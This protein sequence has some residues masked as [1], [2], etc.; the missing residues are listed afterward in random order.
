MKRSFSRVLSGSSLIAGTMIGAGML[1]I[2]LLTANCGFFPAFLITTLVWLFMAC[3]GLLFLEA[4]LWAPEG[5]H[6]LTISEI[7]LGKKGK[8]LTGVMFIFLYYCL[9]VA[10]LAAGGPLLSFGLSDM[11][12]ELSRS[13]GLLLFTL[14]FGGIVAIGSRSIDR[15]NL[16][17]SVLMMGAW[18]CLM[19]SGMDDVKLDYL[20]YTNWSSIALPMPILFSAF[21][22]HNLIPSLSTYL[23][24]DRRSLRTAIWLG[25][26][27]AFFVYVCW[28][29]LILGSMSQG[30]MIEALKEGQPITAVFQSVTR[31]KWFVK[32]AQ[33][34]SFFAIATSTLGVSFSLVDFLADGCGIEKRK[35]IRRVALA[36][37]VF[38]P[39]FLLAS[40]YPHV[41]TLSLEVAG[42]FGEA[43][44]NGMLP[45]MV[46]WIGK[47]WHAGSKRSSFLER[48]FVLS[49]LFLFASFVFLLELYRFL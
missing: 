10:Y 26:L 27:I 49:F 21:G 16:V 1:G 28:Q 45:I 44:L 2:P 32:T 15:I 42:G 11:G 35:G 25:S 5:A 8:Y 3:T 7:F 48:N 37:A 14:L 47:K 13:G 38:F 36:L 19:A 30:S 40:L 23:Q 34:F 31:D 43:F 22:F 41:F 12:I 18:L 46:V 17:L 33:F 6:F 39:P 20:S 4:S 29:W 24:R 9:M